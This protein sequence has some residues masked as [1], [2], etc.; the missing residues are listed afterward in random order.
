MKHVIEGPKFAALVA[1]V[2]AWALCAYLMGNKWPGGRLHDCRR[3][4]RGAGLVNQIRADS[5]QG[6]VGHGH[7]RMRSSAPKRCARPLSV[8]PAAR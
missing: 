3:A 1:N 7:R 6:A 5:T 2:E 4:R 8:E